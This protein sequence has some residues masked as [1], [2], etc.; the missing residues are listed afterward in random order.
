MVK[1]L[2]LLGLLIAALAAGFFT[3]DLWLNPNRTLVI[4]M[5]ADA[6]GL[7]GESADLQSV[8]RTANLYQGL[9]GFD[10]NLRVIPLLAASWANVSPTEW[11]FR[12]RKDVLFHDGS[13]FGANDVLKNFDSLK[14]THPLKTT[15][16]SMQ[17][18][19]EGTLVIRTQKP[20]PLLLSKLTGFYIKKPG[21][22]G[23]GPYKVREWVQGDRLSLA[24]FA[25]YWGRKPKYPNADYVVLKSR[26]E[27]T[28]AFASGRIDILGAVPKEEIAGLERDRL[29]ESY[30]LEVGFL[31]FDLSDP[32]LKNRTWR[33]SIADRIDPARMEEIGNHFV[34]QTAEFVAPGVFGYNPEIPLRQYDPKKANVPLFLDRRERLALA[35]PES[36]RVLGEYL[37]EVLRKAGFSVLLNAN[38]AEGIL[39]TARKNASPLLLLGWQAEDGDAQ[40][41]LEAFAHSG[42]EF[43]RGRYQNPEADRLIEAARSEMNP[44]KRLKTLQ[45]VMRLLHDDLIG[46]PLFEPSRLYAVKKGVTWGPRLDGQVLAAEVR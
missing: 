29:R 21:N 5:N 14:N 32:L 30:G 9:V 42:G 7:S 39:D 43:N 23:T 35:F 38:S 16:A 12:L 6:A 31:L 41:F 28:G 1:K 19:S 2:A 15:V 24:A 17:M 20:D 4:A 40:G 8:T 34:R 10:R 44:E 3:K 37:G 18:Q 11:H 26:E 27:R 22:V 46:V 36:Y 33:Q 45:T 25:D 13:A